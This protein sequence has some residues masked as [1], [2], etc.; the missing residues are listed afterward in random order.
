[1]LLYLWIFMRQEFGLV[2][3]VRAVSVEDLERQDSTPLQTLHDFGGGI[4]YGD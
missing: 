4:S 3:A 1:M 2:A